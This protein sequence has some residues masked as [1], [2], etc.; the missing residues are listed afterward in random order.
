VTETRSDPSGT[1]LALA[2]G[3]LVTDES[4]VADLASLAGEDG[5][6]AGPPS[7]EVLTGHLVALLF[8]ADEPVSLADLAR[9]LQVRTSAILRVAKL[10][11]EGPP[12][13]L[14]LQRDDDRFQLVTAPTSARYIRRLRG[15]EEQA[16]LS[17]AALE[18]L[19]V[20]AYRQ[21]ST[22]A[23]IEAIRG[24]NG[25][26]ALAT[27]LARGLVAEVGRRDTVGRPILFG[28]TLGF[29]EH[30]GL[31]SLSDL[32]TVP[33]AEAESSPDE[34]ETASAPVEHQCD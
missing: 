26:R 23:E 29:L 11:M 16:R 1:E 6:E 32:P 7:D 28:T 17:R 9:L 27:L 13:G 15:L 31:G 25:D 4:I 5:D 8:A 19:A 22:R 20:I 10:L 18:V 2:G 24:V 14:L 33:V 21:P 34:A 3:G 12:A 30:L